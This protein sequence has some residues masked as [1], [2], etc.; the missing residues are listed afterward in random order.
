[1]MLLFYLKYNL[2]LCIVYS[3]S[4][5][6]DH[7]KKPSD[8]SLWCGC[9]CGVAETS[10]ARTRPELLEIKVRKVNT[11]LM[12]NLPCDPKKVGLLEKR[13]HVIQGLGWS[14][15]FGKIQSVHILMLSF[16]LLNNLLS[17]KTSNISLTFEGIIINAVLDI[18]QRPFVIC[19][20]QYE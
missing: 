1:M 10:Y 13:H 9:R 17:S 15:Q 7:H 14:E 6:E 16:D 5:H 2:C 19:H 3:R 12:L 20:L 18:V 4:N 11:S 8:P